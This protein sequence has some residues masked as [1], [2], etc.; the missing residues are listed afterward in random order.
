VVLARY[1]THPEVVVDATVAVTRWTLSERGLARLDRLLEAPW[2]QTIGRIVCS[3][4]LKARQTAQALSG[5]RDLPIEV[6]ADAGEIDRSA[7]GVL[8]VDEHERCANAC[9]AAPTVSVR[10]W[11]RAI[12][13]QRRIVTALEDLFIEDQSSDVAVVG[14]GGVGTLWYCYLA[15]VPIDRRWDQPRQGHYFSVD[16]QTGRPLHRW[17]PF[18]DAAKRR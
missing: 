4:E 1:I 9:F 14:H 13:A 8:P 17:R 7:T 5:R 18:E 16:L 15:D 6:R 12:D 2:L 11:E 3:D 10:G